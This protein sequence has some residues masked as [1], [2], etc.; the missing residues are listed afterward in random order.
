MVEGA[1]SLAE[2]VRPEFPLL[3]RRID[4]MVL[5]YLDSAAT[6]L[7]PQCV[8]DAVMEY[9]TTFTANI[10]RGRHRLSEEASDRYE[11]AR[12]KVAQFVG[13]ASNEVIF[14]RNTTEALNLAAD[15][16][17]LS[18]HDRVVG[19]LDSHHSQ[20]LPWTARAQF[21]A[22]GLTPDWHIDM[23]HYAAVLQQGPKAVVVTHC[24]NVTGSYAPLDTIVEMAASAGAAVIV[25]AAQSVGHRPLNFTRLGAD[26]LA[27]SSH[28]MLGPT[29]LGCLIGKSTR[30]RDAQPVLRGGGTVDYV[31]LEQAQLRKAPHRFE[32]GTPAIESA[33]GLAAAI[34]YLQRIGW[35][36]I[37]AHEQQLTSEVLARLAEHPQLRLLGSRDVATRAATFS[38]ELAD[39]ANLSDLTRAL[40]DS[41]GIMCRNG[42]LCAQPLVDDFTDSEILR[43]SA[44]LYNSTAEFDSLFAA[45]D[46][47]V[48]AFRGPARRVH[49]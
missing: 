29:G 44:Y 41:Y 47:L 3:Q 5:S 21:T 39:V 6:T 35:P 37:T 1:A 40:S 19:F 4:G 24:S 28:K 42:H 33:C 8:L 11:E 20:L 43:A 49:A 10:H 30:L 45:L 36:T 14:T 27:F 34:E 32:A 2:R 12:Y 9:Y 25:D 18:R 22:V 13:C 46:E 26:F 17:C 38:F 23:D 7:K 15:L 16:L 48:S 31:T